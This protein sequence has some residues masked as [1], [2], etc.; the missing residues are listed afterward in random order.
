MTRTLPGHVTALAGLDLDVTLR[1]D[2][3]DHGSV[4]LRESTLLNILAAI[5]SP[6]SGSVV[7]AGHDLA[8]L[9]DLSRYRRQV[10]GLVFQLHNLL[11][12]LS[13]LVQRRAPDVR[14]KWSRP[15]EAGE[16]T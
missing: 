1:G 2:G 8:H 5:D 12:Q 7:V 9:H 3:G 14:S 15:S 10:V 11:P 6:T 13:A 4:G 16:G